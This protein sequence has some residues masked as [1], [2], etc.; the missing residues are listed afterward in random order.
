MV[1]LTCTVLYC[2]V[3]IHCVEFK[4]WSLNLSFSQNERKIISF[5]CNRI[6]C[7]RYE[8][9]ALNHVWK[10]YCNFKNKY[11]LGSMACNS[12]CKKIRSRLCYSYCKTNFNRP[13]YYGLKGNVPQAC[14]CPEQEGPNQVIWF[15]HRKDLFQSISNQRKICNSV[16][17]NAIYL[18]LQQHTLSD[19]NR[20]I[21]VDKIGTHFWWVVTI[22]TFFI[23]HW[24]RQKNIFILF[25]C[26][27]EQ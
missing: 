5:L 16:E 19:K 1:S 9:F 26:T 24:L 7:Y 2:I 13:G 22:H 25:I 6:I 3:S 27:P 20:F 8:I 15:V 23:I 12:R 17:K 11:I 10:K 14:V 21:M 4:S 18:F